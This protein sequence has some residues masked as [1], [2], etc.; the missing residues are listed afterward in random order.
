MAD[1][2][3]HTATT[4]D[5]ALALVGD[6]SDARVVAG[7][8]DLV[9]QARHGRDLPASVVAIHRIAELHGI[10]AGDELALG[11]LASHAD[12]CADP[13]VRS[14]WTALADASALVGSH[15]TRNVGTVGGNLM[16]ASPAMET[17]GPL[18]VLGG[19]VELRSAS[20][21]RELGVEELW[22]GPGRTAAQP[23]ELLTRVIVPRPAER[24]G[25]A[26]V[27]LE[28]RRAMEIA[29]VG[30][31]ASATLADDGTVAA[32][33]V[34]LTALA[35]TIIRS[36]AAEAAVI[37]TAGDE[38]ALA[39]AQAGAAAD[40][41]PISDLRASEDYRRAMAGVIAKRAIDVALRR[42]R[43]EDF[44]VP[45]TPAFMEGSA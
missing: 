25:S 22:T 32:C 3:F 16:N 43:G 4:V 33:R 14:T 17:G 39:A 21:S 29:I 40:A 27:R 44:P 19:R 23:G 11:A 7:G 34:A 2:A 5:E 12:I 8:S 10:D 45:A 42:A 35:P 38:A 36:P 24:S 15:A 13:T 28:Y 18:V 41:Q 26:Y 1:V 31:S 9:V 20:G 37:G 6:G 30:A